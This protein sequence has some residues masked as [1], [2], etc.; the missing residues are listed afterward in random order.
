MTEPG[1]VG[2]RGPQ[3]IQKAKEKVKQRTIR[4]VE[5][6]KGCIIVGWARVSQ[7]SYRALSFKMLIFE[8]TTIIV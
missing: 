2:M 6:F 1:G 8:I 7:C 5:D 3:K 4:H